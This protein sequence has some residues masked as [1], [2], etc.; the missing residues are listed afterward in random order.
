M[1]REMIK[2][3]R[4]VFKLDP[5]KELS[6][7]VLHAVATS[8]TD[9][10]IIGGTDN[11][12]FANT[13]A[14]W[15]RVSNYHVPCFQEISTPEAIL[16]GFTGYLAPTVLNTLDAKWILGLHHQV[17]KKYGAFI[18]WE[19]V[20]IEAYVVLNPAA[21]VAE[22]TR[23]NTAITLEDIVAYAQMAE[24]LQLPIFYVEYSGT[25]GRED[26]V[27]V[28]RSVLH[29][30]QLVYGGGITNSDQAVVMAQ[31]ADIV[32]VGNAVYQ[33]WEQAIQTVQRVKETK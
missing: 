12:T 21:K 25:Y 8:G 11:V 7:E 30:T 9:A 23:A 6:D 19:Q 15:E 24:W 28:V 1:L 3:W 20:L 10:I 4:H 17:I 26:V 14:L 16:P 32:V 5:A 31:W 2:Q 22:T 29:Q 13:A 33:N 27:R 18:P